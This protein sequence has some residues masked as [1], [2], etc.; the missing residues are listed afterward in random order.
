MPQFIDCYTFRSNTDR[1]RCIWIQLFRYFKEH[2]VVSLIRLLRYILRIIY[3]LYLKIDWFYNSFVGLKWEYRLGYNIY[4][5]AQSMYIFARSLQR[6]LG[7]ISDTI[8]Y[9]YMF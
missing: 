1:E 3:Y 2:F 8:N 5:L 6:I 4:T 9:I 7:D